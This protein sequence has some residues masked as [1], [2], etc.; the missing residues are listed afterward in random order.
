MFAMVSLI[1]KFADSMP[2]ENILVTHIVIFT[3]IAKL[4]QQLDIVAFHNG[5]RNCHSR[6]IRMDIDLI[7]WKVVINITCIILLM[8]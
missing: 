6:L 7:T 2:Y 1:R 5:E 3:K 8:Y 4:N